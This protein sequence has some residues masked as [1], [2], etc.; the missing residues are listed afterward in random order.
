MTRRAQATIDLAALRTNLGVVRARAPGARVCAAVKADAYGHGLLK[1]AAALSDADMLAVAE[2]EAA[3]RLREA[4]E[5]RPLMLLSDPLTGDAVS[6]CAVHELEPVLFNTDQIEALAAGNDQLRVWIKLDTGM[7]RLGFPAPDAASVYERVSAI[8]NVDIAGW[9][10]H[11]AC[12]DDVDDP[13]TDRQLKCF[14]EATLDLPGTRS[15]AN[16]AGVCAW[17]DSHADL[18][19]PGIMLYGASPLVD[20]SAEALGLVPA[21]TL[22]APLIS[23]GTVAAG[24]RIGYGGTWQAPETMPVGV[25]AIGYGDGYPRHAP[26]GTPVLIGGRRVPMVGRVSMDMITVDLRD[27]PEAALGD[28][29][30]LWGIGLPA[31]DVASAADTIAYELFCRLTSRVVFDYE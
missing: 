26:S 10:T 15:I 30:T 11:L 22:R 1:A 19:R 21:M 14:H 28:T 24:E 12:A 16:S 29:A 4:G 18:V 7:H 2:L 13:A 25:V 6:A 17:P 20:T 5:S 3:L 31:D 27:C 9:L 8:G 23:V